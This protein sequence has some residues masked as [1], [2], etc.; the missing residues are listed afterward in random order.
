MEQRADASA[1]KFLRPKF[2]QMIEWKQDR[3]E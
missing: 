3:H 2:L 1:A